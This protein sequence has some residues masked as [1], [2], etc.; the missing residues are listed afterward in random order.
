MVKPDYNS[1]FYLDVS[2]KYDLHL[3]VSATTGE[4]EV[5]GFYSVILDP[6][7][8]RT[9]PCTRHAAALKHPL[10]VNT[11]Y[12]VTAFVV[13]AVFSMIPGRESKV[14]DIL[15]HNISE[16]Q[17]HMSEVEEH[18]CIS[19]TQ[20][21]TKACPDTKASPLCQAVLLYIDGSCLRAEGL[22]AGFA[23]VRR[24]GDQYVTVTSGPVQHPS[25]QRV[26]SVAIKEAL[27][28]A[29]NR[30]VTIFM[31]SAFIY[32]VVHRDLGAWMR[33]GWKTA[34]GVA[35]KHEGVV[36]PMVKL[37]EL[38]NQPKQLG[39]IKVAAHKNDGTPQDRGNAERDR[40]AEHAAGVESLGS[41][42]VLTVR[43]ECEDEI[44]PISLREWA[45]L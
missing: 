17:K 31:D 16:Q 20:E 39:S 2:G 4:R 29:K 41:N 10:I 8:L 36:K 27:K 3:P 14:I 38:L 21:L 13:S 42:F 45:V 6:I 15:T 25:A 32:H 9:P 28:E 34:T 11:S 26:E 23:V 40:A 18:D 30:D 43:D 5:L 22:N 7:E 24:N 19:L 35:S 1:P 44:R 33:N 12:A 37:P